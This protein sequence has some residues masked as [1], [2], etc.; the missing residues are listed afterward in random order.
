MRLRTPI[1]LGFLVAFTALMVATLAPN[2]PVHAGLHDL[3]AT[4]AANPTPTDTPIPPTATAA[5]T[6]TPTN[7]ATPSPT[8]TPTEA[9][10]ATPSPTPTRVPITSR[11]I[12]VDQDAQIMHIYEN[13]IE[14]KSFPCSTGTGQPG[15]S[16]PPWSGRVGYYVGTF[17][18]FG[19]YADNGWFLFKSAGDILIHGAPYVWENGQK[20]YQDMDAFGNRPASHGCIRLR[21]EDALWLTQWHPQG[22][23]ITIAPRTKAPS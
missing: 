11:A 12:F 2:V 20:V 3:L 17:H 1:V 21:P 23:P 9:P 15:E 19:V 22:V 8:A 5:P 18:A 14:V 13:G 6:A 10:T 7:T 16:T 4:I